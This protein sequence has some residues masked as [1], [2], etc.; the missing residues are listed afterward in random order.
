M[1]RWRVSWRTG[2]ARLRDLG[3]DPQDQLDAG[4]LG[5]LADVVDL[6][7]FHDPE[8][9]GVQL[10]PFFST[11]F[12]SGCA[13]G[14]VVEAGQDRLQQVGLVVLDGEQEVAV[15]LQDHPGQGPLGEQGVGGEQPDARVML[16]QLRRGR[17]S[18]PGARWACRR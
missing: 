17:A 9:S 2:D 3:I 15:G 12:A 14:G 13:P 4:E 6:L 11:D 18:A 16:E 5:R 7:A 8:P 10:V 1:T